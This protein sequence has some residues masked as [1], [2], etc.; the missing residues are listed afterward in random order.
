MASMIFMFAD[1]TPLPTWLIVSLLRDVIGRLRGVLGFTPLAHR[2]AAMVV[3]F[4]RYLGR[5]LNRFLRLVARHEAGEIRPPVAGALP[6]RPSR[7]GQAPAERKVRLRLPVA[8]A[9]VPAA[10]GWRV[11]GVAGQLENLLARPDVAGILALYP[12][13]RAMFRPICHMLGIAPATVPR[14]AKRVSVRRASPRKRRLTRKEREAILWYPN[15]EGQ[16]MKL[17]PK[18][19]P[20]D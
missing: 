4:D 20:R 1:P 19:L 14:V 7:A 17:L 6:A 5:V 2:R 13:A 15:S 10:A 16:P 18:K 8:R 11:N 9:W 12:Q 3:E